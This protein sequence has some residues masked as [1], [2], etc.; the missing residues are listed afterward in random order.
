MEATV[1]NKNS[2]GELGTLMRQL[3]RA[4]GQV[5]AA[6]NQ[7]RAATRGPAQEEALSAFLHARRTMLLTRNML[8][9][10]LNTAART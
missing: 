10:R 2:D 7:V 8:L 6:L 3:V 4:R 9:S 5:R 1:T